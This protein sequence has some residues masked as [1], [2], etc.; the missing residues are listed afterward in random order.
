MLYARGLR[1]SVACLL[2][3]LGLNLSSF[4]QHGS[5]GTVTVTVVDPSGSV[6]QGAQLELRD[7]TSGDVRTAVTGDKGTYT[8]VNLSLGKFKLTVSKTGFQNEAFNS[9]VSEAAQTTDL[10]ATL[11]I[12]VT[13]TT[14]EVEAS[15]TPVIEETSNAIGTTIDLKQIE[16]LPI[17]GRDL[18]QLSRLVAG[19]TFVNGAGTYDGLPAIAQGNNIDGVISSSSR[20]KFGGNS[21]AIVQPRLEDMQEMT[22]QTE[23]LNLDQGFGQANMQLNFVTRRGSN[24]F[25]GRLYEDFRNAA[26]NANSWT[27]DAI[28][29]LNPTNPARKNPLILNEFGASIGGPIIK[30]KLF[31]FG[32]YAE[33]KQPGSYTAKNYVFTSAAQ[34]GNFTYNGQTV[35]LYTLAANYNAAHPGANLP[36]AP[37]ASTASIFSS[38]NSAE[39]SGQLTPSDLGDPNL[40]NLNWQVAN[41]TTR[42]FPTVRVDYN[43]SDKLRFNLAWNMSKSS[44]PGAH[45]PDF[46]GSAWSKTGAGDANKNY[47][48][49]FGFDWTLSPNLVNEFR[50]GF[51]YDSN[52]GA[53][54][55]QPLSVNTPQLGWNYTNVPQ[56]FNT[57]M[58]GTIFYTGINTY[59][60]VFNASDTM[61]WQHG[62]H[63]LN[64]GF[65]WWREQDHYYNPVLGYPGV[66]Y[67]LAN[68][69]PAQGAF[70][71]GAGGTLP[72]ANANQQTSAQQLYAILVAR[73]ASVGG[74]YNFSPSTN[75]YQHAI[76]RY[77]LDELQRGEGLFFQDS[78]RLRPNFTLN[79][80]LRWDFTSADKDL[81]N[82]YH[83]ATTAA[84]WGPSGINN[85]FNP[86]SLKG[87][88]AGM[89]PMLT[90]SSAPYNSWNVAPQPA[91]GF[92]WNP[93][94]GNNFLGKM[95]GGDRTVIRAGYSLR[96]FTE[97]Q[98][99]VWDQAS[100]YASF[101]YQSFFLN[102]NNTG[103]PGTFAPGSLSMSNFNPSATDPTLAFGVPYGLSPQAFV[104][105]E[106]VSDFTFN[107]GPGLNGL[108]QNIQQPYTQSWNLGIQRQLGET[109]AL[110]VRY[111]GSRTERQWLNINPDEINIFENGFLTQFKNA[112]AN[113][114]INQAH[115]IT[116]FA[117]NGFPGQQ[118][119]PIFDAA[120]AGESSGGPGVPFSDYGTATGGNFITQLQTGQAGAMAGTLAGIGTAPYLCNLVGASFG[121]CANNLGFSG[122]GA[123]YPIN[124]FQVNPYAQGVGASETVAEGYS[125]YNA[126]QVDFRQRS[127]HGLQMDA[128]YTWS[129]T[130]GI[131]TQNN[132]QGQ[133]AVFTLRNMRLSYGPTL[134]DL[135]HVVHINGTYDLPFGKGR[136]FANRG[137][138]LDRIVGGWTVG[139]IFTFQT[140]SPFLLGGGS[141]TF[142]DYA[143]SGVTLTGVTASQ[144]QSSIGTYRIPGTTRV[145]FINPKYLASP[146]GGGA[147]PAFINQN[148]TPGTI[149]QRVWLYGPHNTYDDIS[150]TKN[151]PI[152]ERYRFS[153]QAEMI[154]AFNHP[155]FGPG[156]ANGCTYYCF[157]GGFS[158]FVQAGSF[159]VGSG[160]LNPLGLPTG[161]ARLIELRG[162]FEF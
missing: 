115:G 120:F 63:T 128:N 69:D 2:L 68:G 20:M 148:T 94:G 95:M 46:P 84:I 108:K 159:G 33:D 40:E 61:T 57:Q 19:S 154:N 103:A 89:N 92:A 161:G 47:T 149:G 81:S 48:A 97:P 98:Q 52:L 133:G 64:Y 50:G 125:N 139:T 96:K 141:N 12:G 90:Q 135:R 132:W 123:G 29:V 99:Y 146:T 137:G 37:S 39:G 153:L 23:Q 156:A 74:S 4:A 118:A 27:N 140:G 121:P 93:S 45:T 160:T 14:V 109:R 22:V 21:Q 143:D 138:A 28:T 38:A 72:G 145:A 67:G 73:I 26:L 5:E 88:A 151:F 76:G 7:L 144:L 71:I 101:Y 31:F 66:N 41:A 70:T 17:Q 62:A 49:G 152:T 122:A 104:K 124:F 130:L 136:E 112:Q 131:E 87:D 25:H 11:Q 3:I 162:N 86:G 82:L 43:A 53:Y 55:A 110:E 158:P 111:V 85:L 150:I 77:N 83:S 1:I 51:L 9:V 8:F 34:A 54:N 102:A 119:L 32:S 16:D 117:N 6:V 60:P 114:A 18:T 155:T 129:H 36:T 42:Y 24:Q 78:Y 44:F 65:S 91:I 116:S 107:G 105:T 56:P 127:W 157:S 147:N 79:Y 126:L 142:N 35:N 80:G 58:S 75:Q 10:T 13:T 113:L 106:P 15:A 100:D 30:N 59:Y 134:F